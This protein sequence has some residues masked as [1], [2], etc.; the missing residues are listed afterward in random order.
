MI[1]DFEEK[2]GLIFVE[3]LGLPDILLLSHTKK[4]FY[5]LNISSIQKN[6]LIT[7]TLNYFYWYYSS[8][9]NKIKTICIF[10]IVETFQVD[11]D[12]TSA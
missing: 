5:I 7:Q 12:F 8:K 11:K 1:F 3:K 2:V 9:S 10:L 4:F 6:F